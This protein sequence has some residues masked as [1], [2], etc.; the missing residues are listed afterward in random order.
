MTQE[1][2]DFLYSENTLDFI[3]RRSDFISRLSNE[4]NIYFA[5]TLGGRY[6]LLYTNVNNIQ[7]II[8]LLGTS[9]ISSASSLLGL[10]DTIHL[11]AAG[12]TPVQFQPYL[13]L[14][15]SGIAIGF[16]DTGIDYTLDAFRYEDGTSKILAIYDQTIQS[17][18]PP[19]DFPIG[20]EFTNEQINAALRSE[21]PFEVVPHRDESG[22]G[23]FLA[24]VAA[25]R[26]SDEYSGAAP[27]SSLIIVKVRKVRQFYLDR[28][29]V[30][31]DLEYAFGS[32]SVM[33]GVEY[34][35]RK[36]AELGLPV[37]ICIGLGG[38]FGS[39]D[40][41][42]IFEDY[43]SGISNLRGVCLCIAAGNEAE[44]RHHMQKTIPKTS[45]VDNIDIKVGES[46]GNIYMSLWNTVADKMSVAVRSPTGE[47]ISRVPPISE[48]SY[49]QS[50]ILEPSTVTI[51]YYFP[52]E[53]TGDQLTIVKVLNA[54]PGIWTINVYGDIV[55]NGT[56]DAWLPLTGFIKEGTEFLAATPYGTVT[57]PSTMFGAIS[58]GAYDHLKNSLYSKSSWGPTRSMA[59]DPTL[60]APGVNIGGFYPTGYGAMSGTSVSTAI[61]A[62]ACALLM[63][64]GIV[65][66]NDVS[67][68]TYQI[69]AYLIRGCSRSEVMS[70]PNTQWG[71]GRLDLLQTFNRLREISE[72]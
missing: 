61:T 32:I 33:V 15:G 14:K 20:I 51:E 27:D 39:H 58:C 40:G 29:A 21:N 11:D 28:Y 43:L 62:G 25:A 52:V 35:V 63:Q 26:M 7:K 56:F 22:H 12:I 38:N 48:L 1:Q 67:L 68:S 13:D 36:A 70:Y 34:I 69:R 44:A 66:K 53:G 37:V 2:F 60:V 9:Y 3:V 50:L 47:I 41:F 5:Q 23:T 72:I 10:Q 71:Y 31:K 30:P 49:T 17:Y 65:Q 6:D 24:S 64:W 46:N 19:D 4:Q 55:L 54:T 45:K 59:M 57:M 8:D 16:V 18:T 42:S